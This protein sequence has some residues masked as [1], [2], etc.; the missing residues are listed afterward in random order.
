MLQ[1]VAQRRAVPCAS[2]YPM[3]SAATGPDSASAMTNRL[4]V[5]AGRGETDLARAVVF[6]ASLDHGVDGIAVGERVGQTLE[7]DHAAPAGSTVPCARASK[8]G[9]G[10]RAEDAPSW[11]R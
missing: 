7:D 8:A 3:V 11:C 5:D 2:T 4:A 1:R 9:S 10:R 6:T